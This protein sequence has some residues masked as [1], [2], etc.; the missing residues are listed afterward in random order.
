MKIPK[1][2]AH[3]GA[4]HDAPENTLLAFE[5]AYQQQAK[6][7]EFDVQLSADNIPVITHDADISTAT[8]EKLTITNNT[9]SELKKWSTPNPIP[10]L[11]QL[12]DFAIAHQ[13]L[14]L[15]LELK[16]YPHA[17]YQA[18]VTRV[19]ELIQL[20]DL[21]DRCLI[22]S[23]HYPCLEII[24]QQTNYS[25]ALLSEKFSNDC[26]V[27]ANTLKAVSINLNQQYLTEKQATIIKE[28]G[29]QL[30]CYTVNDI[31]KA[32]QLFSWGVDSVFTDQPNA[33]QLFCISI[34]E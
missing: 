8:G 26:L 27:K 19:M 4:S 18:L 1:I 31:K 17:D 9:V 25:L 21:K 11:K 2:I 32:K 7:I 24:S 29:Y 10:T 22:S 15:N 23:F 13:D 30:C 33:L 16:P 34:T 12:L 3:R 28:N 14:L 5:L 20:Y 6:M